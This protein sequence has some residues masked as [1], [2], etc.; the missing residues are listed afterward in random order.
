MPQPAQHLELQTM[1]EAGGTL[2]ARAL[3]P[4]AWALPERRRRV[5]PENLCQVGTVQVCAS[6]DVMPTL[7]T[8]IRV[9]FRGPELSPM[10]AAELL[11][12]FL[13][14][15]FPFVPNIEWLVEIDARQWIHFSRRYTE[16]TLLA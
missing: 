15:R 5:T 4:S 11:E 7:E 12:E 9:S 1:A 16:G 10:Q 2:L 6:V 3:D 13:S 14:S 8:F